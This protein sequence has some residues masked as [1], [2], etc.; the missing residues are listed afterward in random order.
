MNEESLRGLLELVAA[1]RLSSHE[2]VDMLRTLPFTEAAAGLLDTHRAIRQGMPE[3]VYASGKTPDQTRSALEGL[4]K[5]HG[6]AL[7]TRVTTETAEL[8]RQ[9]FPGGQ[10]DSSSQ[11]FRLGAM[12]SR[13]TQHV[14]TVVC[15]GTSD[16]P[17]AEEA[18]QTLE[19]AGF[20]VQRIRDVG[21][22]G[23][24]RLLS[25]V[26]ALRLSK[27]IIAI[28]GM[29]GALPGVVSGLVASPVIAV[30]TSVGYGTNF[31]GLS[32]LLSMLNS[33]SSGMSVVN[34][35]NGFGAAMVAIRILQTMPATLSEPR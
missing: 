12:R 4:V 22:A 18:A 11:L 9:I 21:V 25:K 13:G 8:L 26:D 27:V 3:V 23:L 7:A 10:Y 29:E 24:H 30:P 33:C 28:A 17:I 32:A 15:A 1:G 19:F 2:A 16:L 14:V 35:D 6:H 20:S 34:I 31:G 5:A